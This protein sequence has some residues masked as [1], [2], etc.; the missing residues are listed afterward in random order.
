VNNL[1]VATFTHAG[2]VEPASAFTATISWGD[3]TTSKGAITLSNGTYSVV[4]SHNYK[5]GAPGTYSITT[6]VTEVASPPNPPNPPGP[7]GPI[8]TNASA[9]G[10]G[11]NGDDQGTFVIIDPGDDNGD[12]GQD[13]Q[14]QGGG[15]NPKK[16]SGAGS[17]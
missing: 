12:P 3:K 7:P 11:A 2:G 17:N 14:D 9:S 4:G 13:S 6:T 16:N 15:P 1:Q 10:P 5:K 8:G